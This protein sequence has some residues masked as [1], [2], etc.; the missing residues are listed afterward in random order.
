VRTEIFNSPC[1]GLSIFRE[2]DG[3]LGWQG[4]FNGARIKL[5]VPVD[6]EC[7]ILLDPDASKQPN[8]NNLLRV[9]QDGDPRWFAELPRSPDAFIDMRLEE[10][11]LVARSW[12]GYKVRIDIGSGRRLAQELVK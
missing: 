6:G 8:F 5:A 2:E 1:L 9:G 10:D 11:S 4:T 3:T 12:S 7:I